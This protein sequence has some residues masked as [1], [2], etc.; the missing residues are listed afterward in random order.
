MA[1]QINLDL[2]SILI[3][4][5]NTKRSSYTIIVVGRTHLRRHSKVWRM[6][7][8]QNRLSSPD[9]ILETMPPLQLLGHSH[10]FYIVHTELNITGERDAD[11]PSP[12]V[13]QYMACTARFQS[14]FSRYTINGCT[15]YVQ[16]MYHVCPTTLFGTAIPTSPFSKHFFTLVLLVVCA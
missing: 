16:S 15:M 10:F 3:F 2:H 12:F 6:A 11:G 4:A 1:P 9:P 7:Q 14:R 8:P 13:L 5:Q